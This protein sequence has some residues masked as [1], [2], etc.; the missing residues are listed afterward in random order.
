MRIAEAAIAALEQ[1]HA[2]AGFGQIAIRRFAVFLIDRGADRH[3]Q[4]RIGAIGAG[5]LAAHA[6]LRRS[7]AFTC[8]W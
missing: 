6:V 1:Q 4:D 2:L 8:C 3:A 5:H 7:C